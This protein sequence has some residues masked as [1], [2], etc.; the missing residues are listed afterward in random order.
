MQSLVKKERKVPF[1]SHD[2]L[3]LKV[4]Y[5]ALSVSIP[6]SIHATLGTVL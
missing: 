1:V 6:V 3:F 4:Q 2:S 5:S